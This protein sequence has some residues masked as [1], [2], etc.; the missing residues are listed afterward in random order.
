VTAAGALLLTA[1]VALLPFG[2]FAYEAPVL[3]VVLETAEGCIALAVA[4]LLFGRHRRTGSPRA[5]LV[6]YALVVVA[7]ANL[8]LPALPQAVGS[9]AVTA[10]APLAVRLLGVG[11]L[12]LAAVLPE[13]VGTSVVAARSGLAACA[14]GVVVPIGAALLLGDRLPPAVDP[15]FDPAQSVAPVIE[16]HPSTTCCS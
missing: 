6:T 3:H 11:L 5:L 10:W 4:Y 15:S 16:G 2:R 14:V 7:V 8:G 9:E 13:R 1:A 12:T